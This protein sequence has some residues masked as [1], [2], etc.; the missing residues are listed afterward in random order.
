[1][2]DGPGPH[3]FGYV[4]TD[5]PDGM[6]ISDWRARRAAHDASGLAV[7]AARRWRRRRQFLR[8]LV[9]PRVPTPRPPFGGPVAQP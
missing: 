3:G 7:C 8:S 1:M 2:T 4:H 9:W 5:I 6:L